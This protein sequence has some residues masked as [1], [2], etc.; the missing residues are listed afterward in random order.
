MPD[1]RSLPGRRVAVTVFQGH[2][3]TK[4]DIAPPRLPNFGNRMARHGEPPLTIAVGEAVP[5]TELN[6]E[7]RRGTRRAEE[8]RAGTG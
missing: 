6:A 7:A 3:A 1:F 4:R 8:R 5:T 2:H